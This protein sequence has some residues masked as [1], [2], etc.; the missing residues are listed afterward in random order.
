MRRKVYKIATELGMEYIEGRFAS[1]TCL[2]CFPDD[3]FFLSANSGE[4][5]SVIAERL[6]EKVFQSREDRAREKDSLPA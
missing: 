3:V 5:M 4:S 6:R 1:H 2:C